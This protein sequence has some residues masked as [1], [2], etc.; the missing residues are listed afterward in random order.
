MQA[1]TIC[2]LFCVILTQ[3]S[4]PASSGFFFLTKSRSG[5]ISANTNAYAAKKCSEVNQNGGSRWTNV[6]REAVGV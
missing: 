5:T 2:R 3:R 1:I 4:S 6:A